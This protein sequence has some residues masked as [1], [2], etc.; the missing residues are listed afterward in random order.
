MQIALFGRQFH[1]DYCQVIEKMIRIL[2]TKAQGFLIHRSFYDFLKTSLSFQVPVKLF[3]DYKQLTQLN[4]GIFC[5]ISVGGDGTL[6]DTLPF[7]RDTQIPVL[8]INTGRLG[9]LS[10]VSTNEMQVSIQA[11]LD[12]KFRLDQRSL[13]QLNTGE[14]NLFNS[15]P[16]ALNEITVIKRELTTMI[17]IS[18]W[19]ND[20]Y[21]NTYWADGLMIATP[22][23][24]TGYS[25][26]CG[27]PI[28]SPD[29]ENFIITPIAS[30][31][32]TVRPIVIK[33]SSTI[34]LKVEGRI[35]NHLIVMDSRSVPMEVPLELTISKASFKVN[36]ISIDQT[37]FF[38]TIRN[39][40]AWGLDKRN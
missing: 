30:H 6:L 35:K 23:G 9:F 13:L 18:A 2:E 12:G 20:N 36:L 26:S 38:K 32:L 15:F 28:I 4:N 21:L 29:S 40:L 39:K 11:L 34:R 31:N 3:E 10:A 1:P 22:T 7:I 24:S 5:M 37:D 33:D 27:G 14:E 8:G 25:L 17:S 19:V 16:Y